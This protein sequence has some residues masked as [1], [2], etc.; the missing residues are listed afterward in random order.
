VHARG[1]TAVFT[2]VACELS[3]LT[4]ACA[5]KAMYTCDCQLRVV[6][7]KNSGCFIVLMRVPCAVVILL[8][9]ELL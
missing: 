3:M 5:V 8:R 2:A 1:S 6:S 9:C 4:T 7:R